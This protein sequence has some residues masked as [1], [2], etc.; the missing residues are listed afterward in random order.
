MTDHILT[1]CYPKTDDTT[2]DYAYWSGAHADLIRQHVG[3]GLT[4]VTLIK[5]T[6]NPA[7]NAAPP[8]VAVALLR[9]GSKEAM[10]AALTRLGP[11]LD[12]IPSYTNV[13]PL[14]LVGEVL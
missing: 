3:E 12:D 6:A 2:F 7:P 13:Q 11:V 4:D 1:V 5:G 8:F 14:A 9:Y 10:D